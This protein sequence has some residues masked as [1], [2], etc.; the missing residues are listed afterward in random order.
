MTEDNIDDVDMVFMT[1][2][3]HSRASHVI[4]KLVQRTVKCGQTIFTNWLSYLCKPVYLSEL[5]LAQ[6]MF[7]QRKIIW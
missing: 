3:W 7:I 5:V 6:A 1:W 2:A 4:Y